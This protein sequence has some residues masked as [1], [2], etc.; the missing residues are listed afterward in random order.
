MSA[1]PQRKEPVSEGVSQKP[2]RLKSLML[3]M[4][5]PGGQ[6]TGIP[7]TQHEWQKTPGSHTTPLVRMWSLMIHLTCTWGHESPYAMETTDGGKV[8]PVYLEGLAQRLDMDQG[9]AARTW[10]LGVRL[11]IWRNG[12]VQEGKRRL[13]L[14]GKVEPKPEAQVNPGQNDVCTNIILP[15]R[16]EKI[17]RGWDADRADKVRA[18]WRRQVALRNAVL[19]DFMAAGRHACDQSDDTFF[20]G[21]G[22]E[23]NRLEPREGFSIDEDLAAA[24]RGHLEEIAP[25]VAR[26]V[27]LDELEAAAWQSMPDGERHARIKAGLDELVAEYHQGRTVGGEYREGRTFRGWGKKRWDEEAEKVARRHIREKLAAELV[28]SPEAMMAVHTSKDSVQS[29]AGAPYEA[30]NAPDTTAHPYTQPL[31]AKGQNSEPS[32]T[33]RRARNRSG[34]QPLPPDEHKQ[35]HTPQQP[36]SFTPADVRTVSDALFHA[37]G[38]LDPEDETPVKLLQIGLKHI[39][40]QIVA[41]VVERWISDFA[42]AKASANY[43]IESPRLFVAAAERGSLA[44]W[45]RGNGKALEHMV[46]EKKRELLD[47]RSEACQQLFQHMSTF[48]EL[49]PGGPVIG[50]DVPE[51]VDGVLAIIDELRGADVLAFS[52]FAASQ[53]RSI[54]ERRAMKKL[55]AR[56]EDAPAGPRI[57]AVLLDLARQ[58]R[59]EQARKGGRR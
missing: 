59:V 23:P 46:R 20:S 4:G 14:C 17:V 34:L 3:E 39:G 22:L 54:S 12:T 26:E 40:P 29:A 45:I 16:Y 10:Q 9:N 58:Y 33:T 41:A 35:L 38:P 32:S 37:W 48:Q 51:H 19:A 21:W 7:P 36:D 27:R 8:V 49:L 1:Q 50:F 2:G 55:P 18:G 31:L 56:P 57:L 13:Y 47:Q 15:P 11:G 53:L 6:F 43:V 30:Q 52:V 28:E 42:A 44:A 25:A 5:V 24:A